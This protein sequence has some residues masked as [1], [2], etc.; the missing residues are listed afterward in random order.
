MD[1]YIKKKIPHFKKL[2]INFHLTRE[3]NK[4]FV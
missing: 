1:G 4:N 2:L 3:I